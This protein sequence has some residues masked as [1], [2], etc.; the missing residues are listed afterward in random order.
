VIKTEGLSKKF[1]D[2]LAVDG[3]SIEVAPGEIFGYL[4][5]NGAGKTTTIKLLTELLR[6]TAGRAWVGGVDVQED[7]RRARRLLGLVP[8]Q[9]YV[10]P[11]LTGKEFMRFVGDLYETDL[12]YQKRRIPELLEMFELG[13]VGDERVESSSHGMRQKLVLA[14]VLL[15]QP[16]VV[17]LDEPMVGLDPKSARLAKDVFGELARK[18]V[19]LFMCTHV[20]EIAER[21]CGRV[22]IV[23]KG[24]MGI[25]GS[26]ADLKARAKVSGSLEDVFLSLTGGN[27]YREMLKFLE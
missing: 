8:D 22:G 20:L 10:Y 1:G 6:P 26:V 9:P 12:S 19:T 15:H 7:P 24:K 13:G 3:L 23:Q 4:G 16:K 11:L 18:G 21:L 27:E 17:F 14:S 5:P 2:V 25:M